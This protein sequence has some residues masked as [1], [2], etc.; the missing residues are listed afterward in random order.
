MESPECGGATTPIVRRAIARTGRREPRPR[1]ENVTFGTRPR[2][3]G[4][5]TA[6]LVAKN[7]AAG[8][9]DRA[10]FAE[11]DLVVAPGDVIGLVGV[12][13]AGKSTLLRL[14]AGLDTPRTGR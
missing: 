2:I 7:L 1:A 14:L 13:G 9:G 5:M 11:L 8:H 12:N 10:L 4:L 6:T 3:D